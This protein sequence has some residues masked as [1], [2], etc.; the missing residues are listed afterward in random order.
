MAF[1]DFRR[2]LE[3]LEERPKHARDLDGISCINSDGMFRCV[4]DHA[5]VRRDGSD[6]L[7]SLFEFVQSL[8]WA[9]NQ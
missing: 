3:G 5:S 8:L 9:T 4:I 2:L 1:W 7:L 6:W